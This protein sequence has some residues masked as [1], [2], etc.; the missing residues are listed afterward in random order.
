V[1]RHSREAPSPAHD[2]T[3]FAASASDH[4]SRRRKGN[5]EC[6]VSQATCGSR[7]IAVKWAERAAGGFFALFTLVFVWLLVADIYRSYAPIEREP[8]LQLT[9]THSVTVRW[10]T[11]EE[12]IGCVRYGEHPRKL[13]STVREN[14]PTRNHRILIDELEPGARYFYRVESRSLDIDNTNRWFSTLRDESDTRPMYIWVIGDSGEPGPG[15]REVA[16]QMQRWMQG[17]GHGARL[18]LWV[19]LGDI[20]YG[21]GSQAQYNTGFFG[22]YPEILKHCAPWA[23]FGNHDAE[24]LVFFNIFD[25]PTDGAAG[26]VPSGDEHYYAIDDGNVHIL[27]LDSETSPEHPG[28]MANWI[29]RD[30]AANTRQ[31][32]IA[33]FHH[34]PYSD[35]T[36][37]SD[38]SF[39]FGSKMRSMRENIVPI[40]ERYDVDLVLSGHSHDYERSELI[41]NHYGTSDTFDP[42]RHIVQGGG[43][44][45]TKPSVK[46]P[47]NGT[48]YLVMGSSSKVTSRFAGMPLRLKHPAMPYS[49]P[50]MGSVV[51]EITN[52]SLQSSFITIDGEVKD[53]FVIRKMMPP[54]ETTA[55]LGETGLPVAVGQREDRRRADDDDKS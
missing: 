9:T 5:L 20:A 40:L 55:R 27:M 54:A 46:G 26:G 29:E 43:A 39:W 49:F 13:T 31:W 23:V 11:S 12:E 48:V 15:Q 6:G 37:S 34:A 16:R 21:R 28:P 36:H 38:G 1:T 33:C 30:L 50:L 10:R 18:D 41:H 32:T 24:S 51:L 35:G 53:T 44:S 8:Y 42:A 22:A 45:Y 2:E 25:P 4:G 52:D 47:G 3:E 17:R 7:R 19:L 14:T